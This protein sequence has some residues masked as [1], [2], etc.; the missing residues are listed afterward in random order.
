MWGGHSHHWDHVVD[1]WCIASFKTRAR[2]KRLES[3]MEEVKFWTFHPL[4]NLGEGR[5][6]CLSEVNKF[7]LQHTSQHLPPRRWARLKVERLNVWVLR[8]TAVKQNA[9]LSLGDLLVIIT[10]TKLSSYKTVTSELMAAQTIIISLLSL[11]SHVKV[12]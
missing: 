10:Y 3:K 12:V 11:M 9:R 5:K 4:Y 7:N 2:Q 1:Y 6:R 8:S